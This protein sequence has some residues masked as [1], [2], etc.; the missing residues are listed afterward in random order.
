[1]AIK[2]SFRKEKTTIVIHIKKCNFLS[3]HLVKNNKLYMILF[4]L[5]L[6]N[7]FVSKRFFYNTGSLLI[8]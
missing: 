5:I 4:F 1:M 2:I 3:Y 8:I 7:F 6:S